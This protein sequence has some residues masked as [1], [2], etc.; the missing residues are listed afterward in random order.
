MN[1][2]EVGWALMILLATSA[3]LGH[4]DIKATLAYA[5]GELTNEMAFVIDALTMNPA[6]V[7]AKYEEE[8]R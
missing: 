5:H 7:I 6:E 3:R 8:R 2:Y 1:P 4:S